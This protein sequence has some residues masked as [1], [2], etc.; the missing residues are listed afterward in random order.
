MPSKEYE[1]L[2]RNFHPTTEEDTSNILSGQYYLHLIYLQALKAPHE[3]IAKGDAKGGILSL[4]LAA[5]QALRIAGSVKKIDREKFEKDLKT[6]EEK[7]EG[8]SK[9]AK[10]YKS[11]QFLYFLGAITLYAIMLR[12]YYTIDRPFFSWLF[13]K[14]AFCKFYGIVL[15]FRII[16]LM[17]WAFVCVIFL[18]VDLNNLPNLSEEDEE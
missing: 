18:L 2:K 4:E 11:Q 1:N 16:S 5:D 12:Q 14:E 10:S 6:F 15:N 3:S 9:E 17:F 13:C 8:S 7:L